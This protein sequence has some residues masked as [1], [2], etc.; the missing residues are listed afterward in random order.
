MHN[1][2]VKIHDLLG[3]GLDRCVIYGV[4]TTETASEIIAVSSGEGAETK[5]LMGDTDG[6]VYSSVL[7]RIYT[8]DY[9]AGFQLLTQIKG[10]IKTAGKLNTGVTFKKDNGSKYDKDLQKYIFEIQYQE[11]KI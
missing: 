7:V 6:V 5:A 9:L 11:I 3:E 8:A 4:P 1:A 10:E 2:I